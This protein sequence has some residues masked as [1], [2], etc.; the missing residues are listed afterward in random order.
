MNTDLGFVGVSKRRGGA[1]RTRSSI[2]ARVQAFVT[3]QRTNPSDIPPIKGNSANAVY[4]DPPLPPPKLEEN[5]PEDIYYY[6]DGSDDEFE[7]PDDKD[8][9]VIVAQKTRNPSEIPTGKLLSVN[10]P[11][12]TKQTTQLYRKWVKHENNPEAWVTAPRKS[13]APHIV[14]TFSRDLME[15][16]FKDNPDKCNLEG[17]GFTDQYLAQGGH[18]ISDMGKDKPNHQV[19]EAPVAPPTATPPF[20]EFL[21]MYQL[22]KEFVRSGTL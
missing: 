10:D 8:T 15:K 20:S 4:R 5:P 13:K 16:Q 2:P 11:D 1:T 14:P 9:E 6:H 21:T 12:D 17:A 19:P 22:Y 18:P 3:K 7:Y